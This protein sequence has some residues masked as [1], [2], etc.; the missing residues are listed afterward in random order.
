M[1][2]IVN[3]RS[4]SSALSLRIEAVYLRPRWLRDNF[5][6]SKLILNLLKLRIVYVENNTARDKEILR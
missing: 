5:Q 2:A 4:L 3:K 1:Q 6:R